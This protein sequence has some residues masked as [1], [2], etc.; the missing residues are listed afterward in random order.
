MRSAS[1]QLRG[2]S[3][4]PGLGGVA[5]SRLEVRGDCFRKDFR[6]NREV[7]DGTEVGEVVGFAAGFGLQRP[8]CLDHRRRLWLELTVSVDPWMEG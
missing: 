8:T 2:G 3:D 1:N 5:G 4:G 6:R 7:G